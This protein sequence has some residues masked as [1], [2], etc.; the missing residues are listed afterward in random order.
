MSFDTGP[1]VGQHPSPTQAAGDRR[2][3][4]AMWA[5]TIAALAA[6]V[7]G[8]ALPG[9]AGD[10]AAGAAVTVVIAAPLVRLCWLMARWWRERDIRFVLVALGLLL[11]IGLGVTIAALR[12]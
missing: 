11:V 7:A 1:A 8:V 12:R 9:R 2:M 5:T 10:V 6:A 3:G 4:W